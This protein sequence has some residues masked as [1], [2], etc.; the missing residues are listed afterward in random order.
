MIK[1]LFI[2]LFFALVLFAGVNAFVGGGHNHFRG[3][4]NHREMRLKKSG[5]KIGRR[6]KKNSALASDHNSCPPYC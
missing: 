1:T 6:A 2:V 3:V 4:Q 5:K